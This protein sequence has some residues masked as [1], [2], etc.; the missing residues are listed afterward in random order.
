M[1]EL[2][3]VDWLLVAGAGVGVLLGRVADRF[4]MALAGRFCYTVAALCAAL[5]ITK[6]LF[7][8]SIPSPNGNELP[9]GDKPVSAEGNHE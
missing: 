5:F 3:W 1:L 7:Q 2:T 4:S 6:Q 8:M 9:V